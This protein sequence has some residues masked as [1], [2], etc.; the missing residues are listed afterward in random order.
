[1]RK[2]IVAITKNIFLRSR[3]NRTRVL[4]I[5]VS[6]PL[7]TFINLSVS[8]KLLSFSLFLAFG[9]SFPE[10][11]QILRLFGAPTPAPTEIST[12]AA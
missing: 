6:P 5:P 7:E 3:A 9:D 12:I 2:Y 10:L 8:L 4:N 1:M 11:P